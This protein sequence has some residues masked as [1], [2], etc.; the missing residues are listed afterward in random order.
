MEIIDS[1]E[2]V[3]DE[4]PMF[5]EKEGYKCFGDF[6]VELGD[7]PVKEPKLYSFETPTTKENVRRVARALLLEKPIML[8]GNPGAGKSSLIVALAES[9]GHCLVRLNLSDQT[10]LSDLFGH[11]IPVTKSDGTITFQWKDG[12]V[13]KAI[14]DGSWILLDEMNL[15][16]QSVLEGLNSCFDFRQE[17]FIAEL[18][19]TFIING[20]SCRFFACQNPQQQGGNRRALPKSFL[21]R[22]T[23]VS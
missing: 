23:S 11:D 22:F 14:K 2:I 17:L 15:A 13:L 19:K 16:S 7:L 5:E 10:D 8:E 1:Y 4:K 3:I 6:P 20:K 18:N 12:P 21:N 9:T